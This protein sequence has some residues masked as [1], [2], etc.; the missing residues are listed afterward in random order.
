MRYFPS[1]LL[2]L[3]VHKAELAL[4][5]SPQQVLELDDQDPEWRFNGNWAVIQFKEP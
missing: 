3:R 5:L 1:P 2:A 4:G